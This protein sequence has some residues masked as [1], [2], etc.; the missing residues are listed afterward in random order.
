MQAD[1]IRLTARQALTRGRL[2]ALGLVVA[3]PPFLAALYTAS[4]STRPPAEFL[5]S[6][7]DELVLTVVLPILAL[8]IGGAALG[9]EVEDGT[10]IYLTMKPVAR[11]RIVAAKL[12]VVAAIVALLSI[13]SVLGAAVIAG[14]DGATLRVGVSFAAAVIAGA[15]AY[16]AAFLLLGLVTSRTLVIG[17]LYVFLWEATLARL[18]G[19]LRALSIRQYA[20]AIAE[21]LADLPS[22]VLS[23]TISTRAAL[24]GVL[25]VTVGCF[26][27]A[28]RQLVTMDLE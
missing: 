26:L 6:L 7:S 23:V 24:L 15:L 22:S 19:G 20:R 1:I 8:V 12:V 18:F 9:N 3:L 5:S 21:A 25:I 27:L 11:W 16:T 10:L 28:V 2:I 13:V 4:G 17:L 14:R